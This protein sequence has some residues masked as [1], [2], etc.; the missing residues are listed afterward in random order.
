MLCDKL[1]LATD[2]SKTEICNC[3]IIVTLSYSIIW[4]QAACLSVCPSVCL[5]HAAIDSKLLLT[6]ESRR[7]HHAVPQGLC[8]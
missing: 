4:L 2:N 8:F 3:K 1:Y 6:V 7:F 5:S